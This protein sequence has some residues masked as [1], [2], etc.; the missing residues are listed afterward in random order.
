MSTGASSYSHPV[1]RYE[2][3]MQKIISSHVLRVLFPRLKSDLNIKKEH[4]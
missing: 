2:E 1:L 4:T 3:L